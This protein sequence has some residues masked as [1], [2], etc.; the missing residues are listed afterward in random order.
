M[1]RSLLHQDLFR[2]LN[3]RVRMQETHWFTLISSNISVKHRVAFYWIPGVFDAGVNRQG[4]ND[5][6]GSSREVDTVHSEPDAARSR[7][8][9]VNLPNSLVESPEASRM[10][11]GLTNGR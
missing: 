10:P 1:L 2:R 8:G 7:P 11:F 6:V 9:A 5:E 4:R 3:V